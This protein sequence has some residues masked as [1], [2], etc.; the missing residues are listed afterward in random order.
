MVAAVLRERE[1]VPFRVS[2]RR[3]LRGVLLGVPAAVA[4]GGPGRVLASTIEERSLEFIN[5]HTGETLKAAYFKAGDYCEDALAGF[6]R[7]LRDHRSGEVARIDRALFDLLHD[8]A[9][10][11]GKDA[12][13]EV[14]SGYRSPATNA[15]LNA[16]SS[17]V[18]R[19]S[20]HMDGRAIDIRL[21]GYRTDRLRDLALSL[22]AGGVGFYRKSDFVH[23]DTG[24]VRTWA[25]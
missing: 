9:A 13:F 20:L 19:R 11:A 22:Q 17:G 24:R 21:T 12:R 25:G 1:T 5:T 18:A 10:L 8:V 3:F 14:I 16:R 6:D 4:L 23:L 7:V 2:R 15:M